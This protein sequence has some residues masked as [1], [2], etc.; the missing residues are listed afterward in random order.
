[1]RAVL[2]VCL[3]QLACACTPHEVRCDG[4]LEPINASVAATSEAARAAT[5]SSSG[6]P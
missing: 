4:S 1:M 5:D 3:A 2:L 6:V